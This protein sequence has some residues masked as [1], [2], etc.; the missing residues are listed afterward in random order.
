MLA[1]IFVIAA[2]GQP[3]AEPKIFKRA[4][5]VVAKFSFQRYQI[6]DSEHVVL[7]DIPDK[8]VPRRCLIYS[9]EFTRRSLL[10]CNFDSVED[11]FPAE[12]QSGE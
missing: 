1:L 8:Y 5:P 2:C 12:V 10:N 4:P 6:S 11:P 9:N 7:M 3:Q